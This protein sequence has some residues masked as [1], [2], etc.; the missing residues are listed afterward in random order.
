MSLA[1]CLASV[2]KPAERNAV[3]YD[4]AGHMGGEDAKAAASARAE[5]V[6][7][8]DLPLSVKA[9]ADCAAV[10]MAAY[11]LTEDPEHGKRARELLPVAERMMVEAA[12]G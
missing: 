7:L 1:A 4:L 12:R 5:L 9:P 10:R 3:V 6:K 8:L 2:R 11:L